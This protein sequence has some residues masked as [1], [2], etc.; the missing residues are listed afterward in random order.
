MQGQGRI[1]IQVTA[2]D[3][4]CRID[5][6]D[7][8]PGIPAHVRERLFTPFLTTKARGTG[9]G[10]STAPRFV[11]ALGGTIRIAC[12]G[13]GGTPI[14]LEL[15]CTSFQEPTESDATDSGSAIHVRIPVRSPAEGVLMALFLG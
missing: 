14:T 5:V 8:G 9:L 1:Q 3:L 2:T 4:H 12:P 15:R 7:D 6:A 13:G 11:E 10:L